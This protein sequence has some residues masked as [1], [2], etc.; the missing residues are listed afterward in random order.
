MHF[1]RPFGLIL[2]RF[3]LSSVFLASAL[4]KILFWHEAE[5]TLVHMFYEWQGHIGFS[6]AAQDWFAIL[7]PLSPFILILATLCELIGALL[8]LLGVRQKL[9][10]GLLLLFLIPVTLIMHPFWFLEGGPKELQSILFLK[11]LA[12]V[13]GLL[14]AY[15]QA[16]QIPRSVGG[17]F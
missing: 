1:F 7:I 12:I 15:L 3:L 8:L 2:A 4:H 13:G 9:G 11:N 14:L 16:P 6:E 5:K 10:A 17:G